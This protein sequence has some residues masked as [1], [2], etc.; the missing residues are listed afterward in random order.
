MRLFLGAS[1]LALCGGALA[2]DW[3]PYFEG[4]TAIFSYD[5]QSTANVSPGVKKVW[6]RAV[7]IEPIPVDK[8]KPDGKLVATRASLYHLRCPERQVSLRQ[9]V[10]YDTDGRLVDAQ[11][12]TADDWHDPV[13]DSMADHLMGAICPKAPASKR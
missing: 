2:A 6:V 13:P 1:L 10:T 4:S 8:L 7:L 11:K 3:T 12:W 5:A 9:V